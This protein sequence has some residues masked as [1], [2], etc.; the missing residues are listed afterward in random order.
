MQSTVLRRLKKELN[1]LNANPST[2]CSA[3][4]VDDNIMLWKAKIFGPDD[5]PYKGG[6]FNLNIEFPTNYPFKPPS[7]N[8]ITKVYHPNINS[9]GQICIDILKGNW[10]PALNINKVLLSIC[11]LLTDPNPDDPLDTYAADLLKKDK[12]AFDKKARQWT[13]IY[14]IENSD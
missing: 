12:D 7:I 10:S 13:E 11:S 8:F 3:G 2:H 4:P 5:S 6:T 9:E 1:Q 14:A